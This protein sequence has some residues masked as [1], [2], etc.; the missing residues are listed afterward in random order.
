MLLSTPNASCF[1]SFVSILICEFAFKLYVCIAMEIEVTN[2]VFVLPVSIPLTGCTT[3]P[4]ITSN[5]FIPKIWLLLGCP[6]SLCLVGVLVWRL[7]VSRHNLAVRSRV[8]HNGSRQI[9]YSKALD[10]DQAH[11]PSHLFIRGWRDAA[12]FPA[13]HI[14]IIIIVSL[15]QTILLMTWAILIVST[16]VNKSYRGLGRTCPCRG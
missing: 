15:M 4:N 12:L 10:G 1:V 11:L 7:P 6:A 13:Y 2:S 3:S 9:R 14:H 5:A 8:L 16:I